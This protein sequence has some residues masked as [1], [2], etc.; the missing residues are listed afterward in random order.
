MSKVAVLV[1]VAFVSAHAASAADAI[2]AASLEWL[3]GSWTGETEGIA[4]EEHWTSAKS[5]TL[6]GMHRDVTAGRM[7]SFEFLRIETTSQ[8]TFYF[9]SPRS[10][11]PVAFK[12]VESSPHKAV[13]E[14]RAHDFP[15]RILYW[16]DATDTLHARVEGKIKG[17]PVAEEWAWRRANA[18]VP[19]AQRVA[20]AISSSSPRRRGPIRS[21]DG[22]PPARE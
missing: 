9:A 21:K 15:Q 5:G 12:L 13:F 14:N 6:L 10:S 17:E 22:F 4:M 18:C 20:A 16:L 8:G 19:S 1:L 3:E 2:N 11:A 7:S